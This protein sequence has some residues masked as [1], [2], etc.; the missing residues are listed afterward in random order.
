M[1][2]TDNLLVSI[3][4]PA[5]NQAKTLQQCIEAINSSNYKNYEIIAVNPGSTDNTAEILKNFSINTVCI[6]NKTLPGETRN[7]GAKIA[8]GEVLFFID[9]DVIITEK[10]VG[11]IA[12]QIASNTESAGISLIYSKTT[13]NNDFYSQ[14]QNLFIH[15]RLIQLPEYTITPTTSCLAVRKS[16]FNEIHGFNI[17]MES[18][19]DFEF[20]YRVFIKNNKKFIT[21]KN[22]QVIHLKRFTFKTL[23]KDYYVKVKNM[24]TFRL[25]NKTMIKNLPAQETAMPVSLLLSW[26][27]S[28]ILSISALLYL[29]RLVPMRMPVISLFLYLLSA[30]PFSLFLRKHKGNIFF[31]QSLL[32]N[33]VVG[34]IVFYSALIGFFNYLFG[35]YSKNEYF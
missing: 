25:A 16:V 24:I 29:I 11:H 35:N 13:P 8:K 27:F 28:I 2:N 3:I 17:N 5:Y 10:T 1:N 26:F 31:I 6:R 23:L 22:E 12:G 20:G 14:Y 19:E 4:I 34:I 7:N 18:Y 21:D 32:F 9:A 33:I 15:Y 30:L